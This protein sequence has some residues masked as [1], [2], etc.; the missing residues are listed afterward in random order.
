M[1]LSAPP[2]RPRHR[3][4]AAACGEA[5]PAPPHPM[6]PSSYRPLTT[7]RRGILAAANTLSFEQ[8]DEAVGLDG[9]APPAASSTPGPA[10]RRPDA[11]PYVGDT[12]LARLLDLGPRQ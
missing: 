8:L 12:A 7:S 1:A 5:G 3:H 9:R 2:D 11:V 10:T 6:A 4:P